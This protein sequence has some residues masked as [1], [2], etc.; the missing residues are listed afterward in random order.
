MPSRPSPIA[1]LLVVLSALCPPSAA[2]AR[3]SP[4]LQRLLSLPVSPGSVAALVPHL[5]DPAA[6]ARL[7]EAL[8]DERPEI[9][10]TAAR[11]AF[12]SRA[13]LVIPHVLPALDRE[14]DD[15]ATAELVRIVATFDAEASFARLRDLATSRGVEA[16]AAL[17]ESFA[18]SQPRLLGRLAGEQAGL[19]PAML[20]RALVLSSAQHPAERGALARAA[21]LGGRPLWPAFLRLMRAEMVPVDPAVLKDGLASP[22]EALRTDSAYHVAVGSGRADGLDKGVLAAAAD[23]ADTGDAATWERAYREL[24]RRALQRPPRAVDWAALLAGDAAE[25]RAS[26]FTDV[27]ASL[28]GADRERV[29]TIVGG[30]LV[31]AEWYGSKAAHDHPESRVQKTRTLSPEVSRLIPDLLAV[32]G[33]R[34]RGRSSFAAAEI[35]YG[36]DGRPRVVRPGEAR[37]DAACASAAHTAFLVTIAAPT[38]PVLPQTSDGLYLPFTQEYVACVGQPLESAQQALPGADRVLPRPRE[39]LTPDYPKVLKPLRISGI[40]RAEAEVTSRGCVRAVETVSSLDPLLDVETLRTV[41]AAPFEPMTI[42]GR[43]VASRVIVSV[44]FKP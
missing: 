42:A 16:Q 31:G 15:R 29:E 28:L 32:F 44:T 4:E 12:V 5:A 19:D 38:Q 17:L 36:P 34:E 27:N 33:C 11:V 10:A 23:G 14:T 26:R 24:A 18:R 43:A 8:R 1:T 2:V 21:L 35:F 41:L 25:Q 13:R 6:Q 7:V 3:V 30:T 22:D 20:A 37:L 40:V 9:R 39:R